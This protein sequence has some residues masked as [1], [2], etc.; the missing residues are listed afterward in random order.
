VFHVDT[1]EYRGYIVRKSGLTMS[2]KKVESIVNWRAPGSVKD[3]QIFIRFANS[4][5][6]FIEDFSIV[7]KPITDTLKTKRGNHSWFWGEEQD[8]AFE[9]LTRRFTSGPILAHIYPDRK[10]VIETDASDFT[11]GCILAQYLGKP[12]H[13][14][15]FHS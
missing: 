15:V 4:Y 10:T 7:C 1:V 3:V 6:Q 13:P 5:R 8:K 11:Q 2:E 9:E 12:L 14:V